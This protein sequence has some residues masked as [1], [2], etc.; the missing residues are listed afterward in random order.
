MASFGCGVKDLYDDLDRPARFSPQATINTPARS[1]V[2]C[3]ETR[4]V[5]R[6]G[7]VGLHEKTV[8]F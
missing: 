3:I 6:E 2:S 5:R 4:A 1:P 8:P 7:R